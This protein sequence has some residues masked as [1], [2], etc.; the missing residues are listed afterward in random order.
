MDLTIDEL[1]LIT[2]YR[3]L[4]PS[5]KDELLAAIPSFHR[6]CCCEDNAGDTN[7]CRIKSDEILPETEK[8]PIITE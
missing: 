5:G 6:H 4:S 1:R 2:E 7:Q 3:K 8:S